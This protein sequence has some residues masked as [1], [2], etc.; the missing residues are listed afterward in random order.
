[1]NGNLCPQLKRVKRK[2]NLTHAEHASFIRPPG[3]SNHKREM[4]SNQGG[5]K[6]CNAIAPEYK[7]DTCSI[8]LQKANTKITN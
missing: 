5:V 7:K 3:I 2:T 4:N 6:N 8:K 1:M